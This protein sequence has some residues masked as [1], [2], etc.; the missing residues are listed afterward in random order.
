LNICIMT[1]CNMPAPALSHLW[2]LRA[3]TDCLTR[4]VAVW[5][6]LRKG[7]L[8][9]VMFADVWLPGDKHGSPVPGATW[10][11]TPENRWS[12]PSGRLLGSRGVMTPSAA[13]PRQQRAW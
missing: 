4:Q 7:T 6:G 2:G 1:P 3:L 8:G 10:P 11:M 5:A 12:S 13:L 9:E